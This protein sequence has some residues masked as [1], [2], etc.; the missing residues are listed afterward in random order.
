MTK[1]GSTLKFPYSTRR[2]V[3]A[4]NAII[5]VAGQGTRLRPLTDD[6]PKCLVPFRNKPILEHALEALRSVGIE[7]IT[8]VTGYRG[9]LLE[10]YGL[11][12]VKNSDFATTNMVHSLFCAESKMKGDLLV[13]YGDIVFHPRLVRA[14]VEDP[15]EIGVLVDRKWR[16]LWRLRMENPLDDAETLKVGKNGDLR[17]LGKKPGSYD[18]IEGQYVGLLKFAGAGLRLMKE[19]YEALDRS[20]S[21][22][23]K[24]FRNMYMTTFLQTLIDAGGRVR[25]VYVDGGWLEIDS[26]QDLEAYKN[27]PAGWLEGSA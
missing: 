13:V 2:E 20:A 18:D 19:H 10:R 25:P 9:D 8:L 1:L 6:V 26:R 3:A 22:D 11:E 21:Y 17:E 16:D 15:A 7:R 5:L 24:D 23:G 4:I 27:L 12:T 14:L